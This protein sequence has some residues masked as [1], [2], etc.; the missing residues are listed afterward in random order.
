LAG[1]SFPMKEC[2]IETECATTTDR[3]I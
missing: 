1:I 2:I 3:T